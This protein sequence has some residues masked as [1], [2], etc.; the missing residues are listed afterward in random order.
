MKPQPTNQKSLLIKFNGI[1]KPKNIHSCVN[2]N[3]TYDIS[4]F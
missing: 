3:E 1:Y 4:L 2:Y